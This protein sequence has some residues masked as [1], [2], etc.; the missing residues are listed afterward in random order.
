MS[1]RCLRIA[2]IVEGHGEQSAL[3]I[4]LRRIGTELLGA[5]YVDVLPPSRG[6]R[7]RLIHDVGQELTKAV[8]RFARDL[9]SRSQDGCPSLILILV[10]ADDGCAID[11]AA[12]INRTARNARSDYMSTCVVAVKE[13]ETWFVAAAE[14]LSEWLNITD[15]ELPNDPE[16]QRCGKRWVE[17]RFVPKPDQAKY[18]ERVD[19]PRF[20]KLMDLHV[21][22]ER[23]RSFKKLCCELEKALG[24]K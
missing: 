17:D 1:N 12:G 2:P 3:P 4:L 24:Q 8:D 6:K 21:C 20:T 9:A 15:S 19:Q 5:Q 13:F 16:H 18:K 22:R 10:D 14:S 23:S 7:D 11:I